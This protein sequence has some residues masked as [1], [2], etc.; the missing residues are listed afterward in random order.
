M[1]VPDDLK[2][3]TMDMKEYLSRLASSASTPGGGAVAGLSG[4]QAS[5][6]LSMVCNLSQGD[7]FAHVKDEIDEINSSCEKITARLLQLADEDASVF[8]QVMQAYGLP[9]S[10]PEQQQQRTSAIQLALA[11]AAK[12]PLEVMQESS[13]LLNLADRLTEIGNKNLISDVGVAIYLVDATLH[14]AKLNIVINTR[15]IKDQQTTDSLNSSMTQCLQLLQSSKVKIL[16]K[17]EKA[18]A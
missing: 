9:R 5:A 10:S 12:V 6:L 3:Q 13:Q 7:R 11:D 2:L 16:A 18:M 14:S 1:T 4:A 17:V 8:R 15:Q